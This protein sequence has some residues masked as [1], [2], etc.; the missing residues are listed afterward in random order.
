MI[1]EK[2]KDDD[3]GIA[4]LEILDGD[5]CGDKLHRYIFHHKRCAHYVN[6]SS[7]NYYGKYVSYILES[8]KRRAAVEGSP[9]SL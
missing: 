9:A 5:D 6:H 3:E 7:W 8:E 4:R 1:C 2:P